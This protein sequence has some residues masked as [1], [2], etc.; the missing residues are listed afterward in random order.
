MPNFI[1]RDLLSIYNWYVPPDDLIPRVGQL[2]SHK[3]AGKFPDAKKVDMF[4]PSLLAYKGH[5]CSSKLVKT[6]VAD[7]TPWRTPTAVMATARPQLHLWQAAATF[8]SRQLSTGKCNNTVRWA[9]CKG[10]RQLEIR[11]LYYAGNLL[12]ELFGRGSKLHPCCQ[13]SI[14]RH[15]RVN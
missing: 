4:G 14:G 6:M 12:I 3:A 2:E 11:G 5:S 15:Q 10:F 8:K 1:N 7:D 9:R 13:A